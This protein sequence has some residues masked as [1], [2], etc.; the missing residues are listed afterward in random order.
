MAKI[1]NL[2]DATGPGGEAQREF[3][4]AKESYSS[5]ILR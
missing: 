3:A 4:E 5:V 2:E 1:A